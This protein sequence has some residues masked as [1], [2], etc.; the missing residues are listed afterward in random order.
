MKKITVQ[1]LTKK[2]NKEQLQCLWNGIVKWE[3]HVALECVAAGK[4]PEGYKE[5]QDC[6]TARLAISELLK[7]F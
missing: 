4:K 3:N 1:D 5:F 2:L 7:T 6:Q